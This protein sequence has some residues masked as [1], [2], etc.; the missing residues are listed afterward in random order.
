MQL[1]PI[2]Q[3]GSAG[4]H[5]G[6]RQFLS[7][8]NV[9]PIVDVSLVLLI[10]FMITAPL[11][12]QGLPVN[13]PKAAA[14][15]LTRTKTDII[16]TIQRDGNI[17]IGDDQKTVPLKELD[18]ELAKIYADRDNRDLFIKADADLRYGTVV[19][20]MAIAKKAGVERIGMLTQPELAKK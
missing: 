18:T 14:P 10:I 2:E 7:E 3:V 15:S 4:R 5:K 20:V 17:F 16:V 1:P 12:Q 9:T 8:I 6:R 13:L 11:L 19:K